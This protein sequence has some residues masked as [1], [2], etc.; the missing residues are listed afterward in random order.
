MAQRP[1][2][3]ILHDPPIKRDTTNPGTMQGRN[4]SLESRRSLNLKS[5]DKLDLIDLYYPTD[6]SIAALVM[7]P[8][9]QRE[10][11]LRPTVCT[12]NLN[13]NVMVVEATQDSF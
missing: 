2:A 12:E 7:V 9:E 5:E 3:I 13:P 4:L 6:E 11:V 8:P 10:A 1:G